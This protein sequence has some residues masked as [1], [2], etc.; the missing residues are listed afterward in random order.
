MSR[1]LDDSGNPLLLLPHSS[2]PT[3]AEEQTLIDSN[4]A[5]P[6]SRPPQQP[7]SPVA[8]RKHTA[9]STLASHKK[10]GYEDDVSSPSSPSKRSRASDSTAFTESFKAR[11]RNTYSG[12]TI[13]GVIYNL[14]SAHVFDKSETNEFVESRQ[15]GLTSLETLGDFDNALSLCICDH[16]AFDAKCSQLVIVPSYMEFFLDHERRWHEQIE[17]NT[18]LR[19]RVP[20]LASLYAAYCSEKTGEALTH[21]LYTAY[22]VVDYKNKD[23]I[24]SPHQFHWH[25]DPGAI[26]WKARLLLTANLAALTRQPWPAHLRELLNVRNL[27]AELRSLQDQGNLAWAVA[28]MA[29]STSAG[30]PPGPSSNKGNAES[31]PAPPQPPPPPPPPPPA[32][33]SGGPDAPSHS[34]FQAT[35]NLKRKHVGSDSGLGV[36]ERSPWKIAKA[37]DKDMPMA[38]RQALPFRWGGP[39]GSAEENVQ[40]WI[41]LFGR[42]ECGDANPS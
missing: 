31:R 9:P 11:L 2:Q 32:P 3:S 20:V 14:H 33:T 40:Y 23:N 38:S 1:L 34:P 10:R 27:L 15:S 30:P 13:C 29:S 21:G 7:P 24:G 36:L 28:S 8:F 41:A 25:G 22:P 4:L 26:L 39:E 5:S 16:T 12:C 37:S 19:P 42:R 6:A 17:T 35:Q 18:P